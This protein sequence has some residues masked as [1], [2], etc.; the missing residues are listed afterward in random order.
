[1]NVENFISSLGKS[2]MKDDLIYCDLDNII[3]KT[4]LRERIQKIAEL[5]DEG[6]LESAYSKTSDLL[7]DIL[8]KYVAHKM[9]NKKEIWFIEMVAYFIT[10]KEKELAGILKSINA[11]FNMVDQPNKND[12]IYLL[13][14]VCRTYDM[15][16]GKYGELNFEE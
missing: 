12:V 15:L 1:M 9:S 8:H 2:E 3:K 6:L 10:N 14:L 13:M 4:L 7:M 11:E 16:L 5:V